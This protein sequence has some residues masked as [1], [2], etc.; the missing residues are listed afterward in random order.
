MKNFYH[1][2][3]AQPQKVDGI[4]FD[5]KKESQY[6][7]QLKLLKKAGELDFFLR[8]VPFELPGGIKYRLDFMEFYKDGTIKYVD[9]KGFM[10]PVSKM[11][12]KQVED[13][14]PI[15]IEVK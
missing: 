2:Y 11:K 1:K 5:S 9:I 7:G 12:I 4:R 8:Q 10:T 15:K 6:Y 14:Y 3:K 13:L